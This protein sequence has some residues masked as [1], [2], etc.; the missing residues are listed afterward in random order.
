M[1]SA[2]TPDVQTHDVDFAIAVES[3]D[4]FNSLKNMLISSGLFQSDERVVHRLYYGPKRDSSG[5]PVDI[6]PFRGV[7][8]QTNVIAWPPDMKVLMNVT[9]YEDALAAAISVTAEED[10]IVRVASLPGLALLKFFAWADRHNA[11][12]QDAQDL[13]ILFADTT[14]QSLTIVSMARSFTFLRE[15][16]SILMPL[17]RNC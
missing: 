10:L 7:E 13:V 6:L 17:A 5:Y 4:E 9:G 14:R 1:F 16:T 2:S 11:T 8:T 15:S 3:W 12:P